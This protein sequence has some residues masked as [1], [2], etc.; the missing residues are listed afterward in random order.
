VFTH[1]IKKLREL[2][3]EREQLPALSK[4]WAHGKAKSPAEESSLHT[5]V[6]A[7][8]METAMNIASHQDSLPLETPGEPAAIKVEHAM[9]VDP[10]VIIIR[11]EVFNGDADDMMSYDA[12]LLLG[13][14]SIG[15]SISRCVIED[16]GKVAG[17]PPVIESTP[18]MQQPSNPTQGKGRTRT[19]WIKWM[20][21]YP[22]VS[23]NAKMHPI[24]HNPLRSLL[25]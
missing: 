12:D 20:Q 17:P 8:N 1:N 25:R 3:K 2:K 24:N 6:T 16:C 10:T 19:G 4:E 22:L 14:H 11:N 13:H 9:D 18:S 21:P 7:Y 5:A 15:S 23:G